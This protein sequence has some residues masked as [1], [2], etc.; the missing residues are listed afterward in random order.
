MKIAKRT[1]EAKL[2]GAVP[3]GVVPKNGTRFVLFSAPAPDDAVFVDNFLLTKW[4]SA[5]RLRPYAYRRPDGC[6]LSQNPTQK[7][8]FL[9]H[10]PGSPLR[11]ILRLEKTDD[12]FCDS[13]R[14]M[15]SPVFV[16]LWHNSRKGLTAHRGKSGYSR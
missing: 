6:T 15:Q 16:S 2:R 14:E 5:A 1:R 9:R 3:E 11:L 7:G 8:A 12:T 13:W 4:S 10:R